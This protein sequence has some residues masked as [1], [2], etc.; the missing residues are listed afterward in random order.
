MS[1]NIEL[2]CI[3]CPLGCSIKVVKEGSEILSITGNTC[4]RGYEYAQSE[5]LA[6]VRTVTST[7]SVNGG[8]TPVVPVKTAQPVPKEKIGECMEIIYGLCVDSPVK[9]G[10]VIYA[11]IAGT[12]VDLV[13][14]GND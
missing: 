13:A 12:G 3:G 9:T 10:D 11:N 14:S 1:E 6:P 7:V 8:G 4:K 2:T 5:V